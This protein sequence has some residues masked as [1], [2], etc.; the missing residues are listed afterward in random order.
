[1]TKEIPDFRLRDYYPLGCFFPEASPNQEFFHSSRLLLSNAIALQP[2]A[3]FPRHDY[4]C[5]ENETEFGLFR[6]RSPLLT[7]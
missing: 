5:S 4:A 6:F 2:P 1:M 7:K 3:S